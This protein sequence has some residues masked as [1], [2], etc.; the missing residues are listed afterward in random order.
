MEPKSTETTKENSEIEAALAEFE[1]KSI[2]EE[3]QKSK[4]EQKEKNSGMTKWVVKHSGKLIQNE[5]QANWVLLTGAVLIFL[6]SGG[7]FFFA[8]NKNKLNPPQNKI[9]IELLKRM[10][11]SSAK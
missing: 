5:N 6:I 4:V 8:I 7:L 11:K 10:E 3:V 9:P 2:Q 1:V